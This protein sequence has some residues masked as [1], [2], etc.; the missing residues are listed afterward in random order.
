VVRGDAG[1]DA[2]LDKQP[3]KLERNVSDDLKM[4]GAM[5]AHSQSLDS[6]DIH[7]LP[8]GIKFIVSI[9]TVYNLLKP[10]IVPGWNS[11][12]DSLRPSL[13]FLNTLG[14]LHSRF[15]VAQILLFIHG[16]L[17]SLYPIRT[18]SSSSKNSA[19]VEKPIP[20]VDP[21]IATMR[22]IQITSMPFY[23]RSLK[24]RYQLY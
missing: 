17:D 8:E 6:I 14:Q 15:D 21:V 19:A 23:H 20:R 2:M 4:D 16:Q 10:G 3:E 5:V 18:R 11:D 7:H 13:R 22:F 24:I 12:Q 1:L 9:D